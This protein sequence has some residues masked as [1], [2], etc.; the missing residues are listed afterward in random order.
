[1]SQPITNLLLLMLVE[2]ERIIF[3]FIP[4]YCIKYYLLIPLSITICNPSEDPHR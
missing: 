3:Y 4:T 1:M 2:H